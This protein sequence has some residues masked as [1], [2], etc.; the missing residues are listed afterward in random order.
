M[1]QEILY[2]ISTTQLSTLCLPFKVVLWSQMFIISLNLMD[3][4]QGGWENELCKF[5]LFKI[6]LF[7]EVVFSLRS[8]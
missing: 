5:K 8:I 6:F 1:K 3:L 2:Q 4:T 7:I